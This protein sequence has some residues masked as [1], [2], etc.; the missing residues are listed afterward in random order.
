MQGKARADNFRPPPVLPLDHAREQALKIVFF[1]SSDFALPS[2]RALIEAD[3]SPALVVTKPDAPRGRGRK[4]YPAEVRLGA[5]ELNLPCEQPEDVNDPE[6]LERLSALKPE[7]GVVVSYG[8]ILS[9]QLLELPQ[10]GCINAHASLLPLYRGA[11]PVQHAICNGHKE[12]G[13]TIIR[14]TEELD[15]GDIL[16]Q[17]K[18]AIGDRITAGELRQVTV[19]FVDLSGFTKMSSTLDPEET[20]RVLGRFFET[21]DGLVGKYGGTVDKHIGDSVMAVF[22]APVAHGDD[23]RLVV[24]DN[25]NDTYHIAAASD[26]ATP[27]T[28]PIAGPGVSYIAYGIIF[29]IIVARIIGAADAK[30]D[31][32]P[33]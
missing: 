7:V 12:T 23:P 4:I 22:G 11:S 20:H 10:K 19:L 1:G 2:M 33:E 8:V 30:I 27:I 21:V 3:M 29:A 18:H 15:A 6:F 16:L 24:F 17:E 28:N 14:L 26:P 31:I 25:P 13:V 32:H 9:K 5:E